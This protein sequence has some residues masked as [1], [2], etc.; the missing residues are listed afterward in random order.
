MEKIK[1][2][3][4]KYSL[5]TSCIHSKWANEQT[6]KV[7]LPIYSVYTTF[8]ENIL[9]FLSFFTFSPPLFVSIP[10]P[11]YQSEMTNPLFYNMHL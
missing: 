4:T 9:S 3:M 6:Q 2:G 7:R 5:K 11:K 8:L 1:K 10:S